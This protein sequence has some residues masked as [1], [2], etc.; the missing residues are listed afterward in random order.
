MPLWTNLC[1]AVLRA[2]PLL[3][4]VRHATKKAAGTGGVVRTS[5]PKYLGVKMYSDEK[6]NAGNI[7]IR[8][9]G[10][11]WVAG[12]NVGVG[13]DNT[14]F[15]LTAGFVEFQKKFLPRPRHYVHVR[16]ETKDENQ[17]RIAARVAER[18]RRS[19]A[20]KARLVQ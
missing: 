1:H 20:G 5:R 14:L 2:P 12:E 11:R 18:M 6:V 7:I 13:R 19:N 3:I 8:Q 10:L 16:A 4:V 9:R 17:Q 15:A